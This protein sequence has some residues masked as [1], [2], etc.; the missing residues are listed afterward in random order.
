LVFKVGRHIV[1]FPEDHVD[2]SSVLLVYRET[3]EKAF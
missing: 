1:H 3:G 2:P